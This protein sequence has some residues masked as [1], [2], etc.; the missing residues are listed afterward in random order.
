[1]CI[2]DRGSL[3][4]LLKPVTEDTLIRV[5][6]S[7]EEKIQRRRWEEE[8]SKYGEMWMQQQEYWREKFW[9]DLFLGRIGETPEEWKREAE[10]RNLCDELKDNVVPILYLSLIHIY[11]GKRFFFI[12]HSS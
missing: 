6:R 3:D 12:T 10:K 7:V 5:I 8:F 4:Y 9:E 2:R 1:M 11:T